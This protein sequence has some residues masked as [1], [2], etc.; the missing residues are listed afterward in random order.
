MNRPKMNYYIDILLTVLFI[1]VAITGFVLYL[2]I[3]SG[4]QRGRYQEFIGIT[5]ATWTLVHNKSAILLT[6]LTGF[7]FV[8]HKRWM[9]CMTKNLFKNDEDKENTECELIN[10]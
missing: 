5:K 2:A 1:I 8:L 3:P 6:L 9:C 4:V 7:H 10:I